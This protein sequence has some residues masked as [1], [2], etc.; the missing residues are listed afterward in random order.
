MAKEIKTEQMELLPIEKTAV[1]I[2]A[3]GCMQTIDEAELLEDLQN[4]GFENVDVEDVAIPRI[5][6]LQS[7]TP[8]VQ[9]GT[10][11]G[12][13]AGAFLNTATNEVY[14]ELEVIPC[15]FQKQYLEWGPKPLGKL[16]RIHDDIAAAE[17][18]K[19]CHKGGKKGMDD[20]TPDGNTLKASC[21]H[22]AVIVKP[23]GS[24]ERVIIDFASTQ[25]KKSKKWLAT[26]MGLQVTIGDR[27]FTAPMFSHSYTV[28]SA[29]EKNDE[30]SWFGYSIT[31]PKPVEDRTVYA[32]ARQFHAD[33]KAGAVKAAE[34]IEE[35]E[36]TS[37]PQ[38]SDKF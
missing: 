30:G 10:V 22:Y 31:T 1:A 18:L 6:L 24:L 12:A 19:K 23:D 17:L 11:P 37:Q 38:V 3:Q 16:V 25:I 2:K 34:P 14:P 29:I 28:K 32:F 15:A 9:E 20:I 13:K 5:K 8:A 26:M 27:R 33:V 4:S 7:N 36:G 35:E 21:S